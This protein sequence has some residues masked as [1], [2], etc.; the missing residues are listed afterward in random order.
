MLIQPAPASVR[1]DKTHISR[2]G[3][4]PGDGPCIRIFY[5]VFLLSLSLFYF[6]LVA[7]FCI[8]LSTS[9]RL[10]F[11]NL[12]AD[13]WT[14]QV[15]QTRPWPGLQ[16]V[17]SWLRGQG[18]TLR[19]AQVVAERP[20]FF[21]T[22]GLCLKSPCSPSADF[23]LHLGPPLRKLCATCCW[24]APLC[25]TDQARHGHP[26]GTRSEPSRG[27]SWVSQ[28]QVSPLHADGKQAG[29][30]GRTGRGRQDLDLL[31]ERVLR[32][33][34]SIYGVSLLHREPSRLPR[35][36]TAVSKVNTARSGLSLQVGA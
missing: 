30:E 1:T 19:K 34:R 28:I 4:Y 23:S 6:K 32:K 25:S 10:Y 17:S 8:T 26:A 18:P 11:E 9:G 5:S 7:A 27:C 21:C 36:K 22:S 29:R 12:A 33:E 14:H 31:R 16:H 24:R 3:P 13:G 2:E 15:L 20:L 35:K